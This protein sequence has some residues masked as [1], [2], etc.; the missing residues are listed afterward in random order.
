MQTEELGGL[1]VRWFQVEGDP[2]DAPTLVLMHG[3]GAPG[4][5]LVPLGQ[6]IDAP[7]GSRI[8]FPEAPILLP[9][10]I[11]GG[12]GRAW[13][14]IDIMKLQIGL[15]TGQTRALKDEDPDGLP[16]VRDMVVAMLDAFEEKHGLERSRLAL[17]GF[18]Q[19]SMLATDVAL[20]TDM[21]LAS[22]IILSGTFLAAERWR[23]KL[24]ARAGLPVL[25]SHGRG[26][27]IL[28]YEIA[29]ELR[30]A[31]TEAGMDV[32]F[33]PFGGGHGIPPEVLKQLGGLLV[34]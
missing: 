23:P 29:E 30:D 4:T 6:A 16:A 21:E 34:A 1:T 25:Q 18:S 24:T 14:M 3:F 20:E 5:D 12:V 2:T 33:V 32:T 22:L 10:E 17:G 26:D 31:M 19:G 27:P 15:M 28:P 11:G 13:W 9:P 7:P 8:L